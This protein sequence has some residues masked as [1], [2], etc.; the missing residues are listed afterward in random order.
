MSALREG[1]I[2]RWQWKDDARD[3]DRGPYRSYHC[4]SQIAVVKNGRLLD[5]F[6]SG[7]EESSLLRREDVILTFWANVDDLAV[8]HHYQTPYYR[9]QDIVDLRHSNNS[10]G[11]VYLRKGAER[12]ADTMLKVVS[13]RIEESNREIVWHQRQLEEFAKFQELIRA[14]KLDEVWL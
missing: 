8:I 13:E 2:Y 11:P 1:N 7:Y 4:K 9:P 10:N 3:S 12:D 5:T 14:G 6:W